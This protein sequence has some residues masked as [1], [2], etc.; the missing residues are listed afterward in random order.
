MDGRPNILEIFVVSHLCKR[1]VF[2]AVCLF[3]LG[4]DRFRIR[5]K[6]LAIKVGHFFN[7]RTGHGLLL[8]VFLPNFEK[9][10]K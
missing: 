1:D 5:I 2:S 6:P 4:F 7:I 3:L 10:F 8:A 9:A